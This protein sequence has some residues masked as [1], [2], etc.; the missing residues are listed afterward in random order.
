MKDYAV[1]EIR[2]RRRRLIEEEFGGSID[3]F[4]DK[5]V[6]WA[7]ENPDRVE[8]LRRRKHEMLEESVSR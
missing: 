1:E 7:K 8:N 6:P 5:A 4:V 2:G 3:R